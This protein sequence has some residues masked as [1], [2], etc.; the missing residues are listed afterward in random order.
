MAR[1]VLVG[2]SGSGKSTLA[3]R[4]REGSRTTPH[5]H[6]PPARHAAHHRVLAIRRC[7]VTAA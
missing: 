3:A 5:P 1:Y 7:A 2:N 6:S 4:I